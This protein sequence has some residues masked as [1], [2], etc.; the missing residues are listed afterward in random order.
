VEKRRIDREERRTLVQSWRHGIGTRSAVYNLP[1]SELTL[2][3]TTEAEIAAA[4]APG[5]A[6]STF[7]DFL[8]I[9][10]SIP[11]VVSVGA[12][13]IRA[14]AGSVSSNRWT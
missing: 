11:Y 9:E 13:V 14:S 5:T 3:E 4:V 1:G 6:R 10:R 2:E 12:A 7:T 8:A